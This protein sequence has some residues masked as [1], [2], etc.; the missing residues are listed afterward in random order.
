VIHIVGSKGLPDQPLEKVVLFIGTAGA[1]EPCEGIRAIGLFDPPEF[2]G[3]MGE[4][5]RPCGFLK[6]AI[7]VAQKRPFQAVFTVDE[8]IPEASL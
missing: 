7:L 4:G 5:V 1:G 2:A 6:L 8:G 3:N